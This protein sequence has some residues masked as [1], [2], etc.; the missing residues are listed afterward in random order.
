VN[1]AGAGFD[2][3]LIDLAL[4]L[5]ALEGFALIAWRW[6]KGAGPR[7][8]TLVAN[9]LAGAMLLLVARD[10][11]TGAG[12]LATGAALTAALVAHVFDLVAR[13]EPKSHK[14]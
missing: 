9:L 10:L 11:L 4:A 7:P 12:A 6:A 5:I 1:A 3:R 14:F 8:A 2:P 13:W